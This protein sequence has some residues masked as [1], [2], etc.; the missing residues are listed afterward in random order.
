[1]R[2][3]VHNCLDLVHE[4]SIKADADPECLIRT[5]ACTS[6]RDTAFSPLPC[7]EFPN[8]R[9]QWNSARSLITAADDGVDDVDG[10]DDGSGED[11]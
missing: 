8:L 3:A 9:K 7:P 11:R 10:D 6:C 2:D 5:A 1:M 4:A